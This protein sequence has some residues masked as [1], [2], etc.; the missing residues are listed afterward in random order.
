MIKHFILSTWKI[1]RST[2]KYA[3]E[4]ELNIVSKLKPP[5][6]FDVEFVVITIKKK[7]EIKIKMQSIVN[8]NRS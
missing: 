5:N 1:W 8:D 7:R 6:Q 3:E 2:N 4:F